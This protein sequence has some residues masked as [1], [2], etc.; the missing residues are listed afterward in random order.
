MNKPLG[1]IPKI[2]D[3]DDSFP[4]GTPESLKTAA[5]VMAGMHQAMQRRCPICRICGNETVY[6]HIGEQARAHCKICDRFYDLLPAQPILRQSEP[7]EPSKPTQE[8]P[9][10]NWAA[11]GELY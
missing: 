2:G 8:S 7:V 10:T 3:A 4:P 1:G 6:T 11:L 9:P 5:R